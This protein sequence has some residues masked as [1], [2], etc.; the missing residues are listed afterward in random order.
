MN[1]TRPRTLKQKIQ[2]WIFVLLWENNR[3]ICRSC[4]ANEGKCTNETCFLTRFTNRFLV[5]WR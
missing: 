3:G 4:G 2:W 1:F 5:W